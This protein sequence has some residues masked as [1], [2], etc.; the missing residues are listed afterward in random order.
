MGQRPGHWCSFW[1]PQRRPQRSK[2]PA[3]NRWRCHNVGLTCPAPNRGILQR[4][5]RQLMRARLEWIAHAR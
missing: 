3:W 4:L 2:Q 5:G 1:R